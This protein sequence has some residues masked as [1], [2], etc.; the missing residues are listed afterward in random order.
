MR[1]YFRHS[2]VIF[3]KIQC[4]KFKSINVFRWDVN[5]PVLLDYEIWKASNMV[6]QSIPNTKE[7]KASKNQWDDSWHRKTYQALSKDRRTATA[8]KAD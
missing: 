5:L 2:N 8:A 3:T 4:Q 1:S 6:F 7:V